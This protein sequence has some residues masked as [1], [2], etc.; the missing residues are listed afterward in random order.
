MTDHNP[1]RDE[2]T[3][4]DDGDD[5]QLPGRS[6]AALSDALLDALRLAL[7]AGVGPRLHRALRD[8]FGTATAVL[9]AA[10]SDLRRST[11]SGPN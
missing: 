3:P 1:T 8:R 2:K 10:P 5:R 9:D 6:D 11:A 4:L 7:V